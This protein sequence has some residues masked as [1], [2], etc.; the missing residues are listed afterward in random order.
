MTDSS[1]FFLYTPI[2][3]L[4]VMYLAA[5]RR[6]LGRIARRIHDRASKREWRSVCEYLGLI[7]TDVREP[8]GWPC[9]ASLIPSVLLTT[10]V[11]R[12]GTLSPARFSWYYLCLLQSVAALALLVLLIR[13]TGPLPFRPYRDVLPFP[14]LGTR[15]R[16]LR[17][18][19]GT[20]S[21]P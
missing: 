21:K 5:Y 4:I 12:S 8:A 20:G 19:K 1:W 9:S 10:L 11:S 13:I 3:Y 2:P 6:D 18:Q 7:G 14:R 16:H 17:E 15:I